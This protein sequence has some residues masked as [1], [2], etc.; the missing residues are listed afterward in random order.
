MLPLPKARL[1]RVDSSSGSL[2]WEASHTVVLQWELFTRVFIPVCRAS[3][4]QS[5]VGEGGMG[6][7]GEASATTGAEAQQRR[8]SREPVKLKYVVV[9]GY[10]LPQHSLA[11]HSTSLKDPPH[12]T[13]TFFYGF[14]EDAFP[15]K[16]NTN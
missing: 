8:P 5:S 12:L 3:S 16:Q 15:P 9:L 4:S 10:P 7:P 2:Q 6:G 1:S 11:P 13:S 14:A